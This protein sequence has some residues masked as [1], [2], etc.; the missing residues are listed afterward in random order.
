MFPHLC[1][2]SLR[3]ISPWRCEE[4]PGPAH[5][6]FWYQHWAVETNPPA[7]RRRVSPVLCQL[8]EDYPLTIGHILLRFLRVTAAHIFVRKRAQRKT[9]RLPTLG[10]P[11]PLFHSVRKS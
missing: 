4:N 6:S 8:G 10:S 9:Q 2:A 5:R 7:D 3:S 1:Q 11:V